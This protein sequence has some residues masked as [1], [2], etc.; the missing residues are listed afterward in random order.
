[1]LRRFTPRNDNLHPHPSL[2]LWHPASLYRLHPCRRPPSRGKGF[3]TSPPLRG[4]ESGEG[5]IPFAVVSLLTTTAIDLIA[6]IAKQS[7]ANASS[8]GAIGAVVISSICKSDCFVISLLVM[9]PLLP[10]LRGQRPKQSHNMSFRTNVRNLSAPKTKISQSL[11]FFEMTRK[12]HAP[13]GL[14]MT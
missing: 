7:D 11:R 10:S 5:V 8:R 2:R 4:G 6:S 9:T 13:S 3:F 12:C 14:A 1:M